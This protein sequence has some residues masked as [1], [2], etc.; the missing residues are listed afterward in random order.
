MIFLYIV[1][2]LLGFIIVLALAAP[3]KYQVERTIVINKPLAE[4]FNYIKYI[5]NQDN[6]SP[7]KKKDPTMSQEFYGEDGTI[8]FI[9]SWV[10]NKEVGEGEQEIKNIIDN[11]RLESQLRFLKPWKSESDAYI[12]VKEIDTDSTEVIWGFSGNNKVPMNIMMLF[13]NMEKTVG[14]DF[15]EGL[16]SL[17]ELL[18]S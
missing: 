7:W 11:S 5:K 9:A 10:G 3:K 1:F 4:V 14:K 13:F 6:W 2:L 18:E 17:K 15:Q 8:G 12:N 16:E